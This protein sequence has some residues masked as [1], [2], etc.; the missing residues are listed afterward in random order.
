MDGH[1]A[2]APCEASRACQRVP[3]GSATALGPWGPGRPYTQSGMK[4][5]YQ[6]KKRKRAR[7]HGFRARMRTRAGRTDA[8]A[9]PQQGAQAPVGLSSARLAS[10]EVSEEHATKRQA[11]RG[12]RLSRSAEF[13]RVYRHGRSC[14]NRHLV[15]YVFENA[16]ARG[17]RLGLSVSRRVGGAVG[18]QSGQAP[19]ARGLCVSLPA[20]RDPCGHRHR[21]SSARGRAGRARGARRDQA[22]LGELIAEAGAA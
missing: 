4:R 14:A 10:G 18:A 8:Q 19:V 12:G 22:A 3:C 9:P 21:G 5:T 13:E 6:P 17:P 15:L 11:S 1:V 2:R 20:A 7:V 16:S